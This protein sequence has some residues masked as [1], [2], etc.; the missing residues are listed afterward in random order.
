MSDNGPGR[1]VALAHEWLDARA[2]SEKVFEALA[3]LLPAADLFALTRSQGV[4]FDLGG[5]EVTTTF[6]QRAGPLRDRRDLTLPLMP[7]AW[8]LQRAGRYDLVITSSHACA[9]GFRPGRRATHLCYCHTPLRYAWD[10]QV[11]LRARGLGPGRRALLAALRRWDRGSTRWV[12]SFA[13]NSTVVRDRIRDRYDRDAVVIAPPVDTEFFQ[14]GDRAS[15]PF[16]LALSRFIPYKRLDLAIATCVRLGLPL[17]VAGSGPGEASLR[18]LAAPAGHL[19]TFEIRP[20]DER[21]RELYQQAAVVLFPAEE[22]FG[23]VPVEAQACGTPVVAF[24][25]GG[26]L[27]TV[28]DGRTGALV[29]D[30]DAA[31]F[32]SA[33]EAVLGAGDRRDACR[34]NAERFSPAVFA[35]RVTEWIAGA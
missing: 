20:T 2:G 34:R 9:K 19:V 10:P 31:S 27:D 35:A 11:D 33:V 17:T 1:R 32:A 24:G 5:R 23:I 29:A 13:A 25:R 26:A 28:V 7:L 12:D 16:A 4:P 30:Q 6:L 22:D 14:P 21:L 3:R 15:P 8:S 18:A